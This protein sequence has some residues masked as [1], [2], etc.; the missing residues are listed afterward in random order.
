MHFAMIDVLFIYFTF[1]IK[2]T[3]L[4]KHPGNGFVPAGSTPFTWTNADHYF[5]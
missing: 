4:N 2:V 1:W 5:T 3:D